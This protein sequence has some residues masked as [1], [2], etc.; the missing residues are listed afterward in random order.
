VP[1]YL[2]RTRRTASPGQRLVLFARDRG[3]TRPGCTEPADRYQAHNATCDW[4]HG[5]RTDITDLALACGA[6]N[7]LVDEG[8]WHTTMKNG[9]AHWTHHHYST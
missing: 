2:G 8:G 3:C 6:D 9:R 5:G 4:Q 7:R 1:L